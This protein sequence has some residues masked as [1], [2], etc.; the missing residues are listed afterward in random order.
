[1]YHWN[2]RLKPRNNTCFFRLR[3]ALKPNDDGHNGLVND[4]YVT[5]FFQKSDSSWLGITLLIG[6]FGT[7]G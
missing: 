5:S 2:S 7:Y 4:Y 1:M 3:Y 6:R